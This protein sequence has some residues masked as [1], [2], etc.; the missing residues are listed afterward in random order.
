MKKYI[1]IIF[2]IFCLF[3]FSANDG[4][5][6]VGLKAQ[7]LENTNLLLEVT[8][9]DN[10]GSDNKSFTFDFGNLIKGVSEEELKGT[11]QVRLLKNS[12]EI[13]FDFEPEYLLI[14]NSENNFLGKQVINKQTKNNVILTYLLEKITGEKNVSKNFG[15]LLIKANSKGSNVLPGVFLENNISIKITIKNQK[16]GL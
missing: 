7:V 1:L 10:A 11:F 3:S 6:T 16:T 14:D 4:K 13:N 15:N 12:K 5:V 9:L 8:A 2:L